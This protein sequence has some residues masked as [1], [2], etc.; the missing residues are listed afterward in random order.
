MLGSHIRH[1]LRDLSPL[2]HPLGGSSAIQWSYGSV[3]SFYSRRFSSF[4]SLSVFLVVAWLVG[5]AGTA[6]VRSEPYS[7]V[8]ELCRIVVSLVRLALKASDRLCFSMLTNAGGMDGR[9]FVAWK[10]HLASASE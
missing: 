3:F 6:S 10:E 9:A 4:R 1:D 2:C 8:D 5:T 7:V